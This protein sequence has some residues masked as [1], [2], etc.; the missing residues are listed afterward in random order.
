MASHCVYFDSLGALAH[1]FCTAPTMTTPI[2]L[3]LPVADGFTSAPGTFPSSSPAQ[4]RTSTYPQFLLGS[5]HSVP[6]FDGSNCSTDTEFQPDR[7]IGVYT[8]PATDFVYRYEHVPEEVTVLLPCMSGE[9]G[10]SFSTADYDE[11]EDGGGGDGAEWDEQIWCLPMHSKASAE[12]NS[13]RL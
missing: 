1:C 10:L 8:C 12:C 11:V 5:F 9:G 4:P 13:P 7:K 6:Y 2:I 3:L